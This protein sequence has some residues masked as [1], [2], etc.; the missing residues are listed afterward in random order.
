MILMFRK[1]FFVS[2]FNIFIFIMWYQLMKQLYLIIFNIIINE[3]Y[4]ILMRKTIVSK[5]K[6]HPISKIHQ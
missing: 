1:L 6:Y 5:K 3:L 4:K 2:L